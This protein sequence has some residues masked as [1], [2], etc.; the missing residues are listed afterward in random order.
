MN[1]EIRHLQLVEA[2]TAEGSVTRAAA[3]LNVT[4]SALSHQLREIEDR[5][6]TPLF[7]RVNRRLSLA[8]AGERLLQSAR[9][10]LDDLRAAEEDIGR[11]AAHQDGVI[12][13]STE[14]YTCYQWLPP[15][16]KPFH[17]RFPRVEVEIVADVTRRAVEA[18]HARNIDLALTHHVRRDAKL[19]IVPVFEDE[20]VVIVPR[21]HALAKKKFVVPRDLESE[22]LLMHSPAEESFF[23]KS[24]AREGVRPRKHSVVVLTEAIVELVRAGIGVSAVPRWTVARELRNGEIV[25]L[26]FTKK[27][28]LRKWG[29]ATLKTEQRSE[30]LELL[31]ELIRENRCE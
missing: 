31:I 21:D 30:P 9:R 1:L 18:L 6:R 26:R 17:K 25:A 20:L 27:G 11:L 3:R 12:R 7:L 10:V 19:R 2:I 16:L 22:H 29:A 23:A 4:Q 13:V 28:L 8:P 5:L 14:C 24:L 15:L